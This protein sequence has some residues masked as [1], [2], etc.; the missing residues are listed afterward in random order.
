MRHCS[1][2][3]NSEDGHGA[4]MVIVLSRRCRNPITA[5]LSQLI[6]DIVVA[7]AERA[8]NSVRGGVVCLL[9]ARPI[10]SAT[11]FK[12]TLAA[13]V[14]SSDL[15]TSQVPLEHAHIA[16]AMSVKLAKHKNSPSYATYY[17]SLR[18][19]VRPAPSSLRSSPRVE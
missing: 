9:R 10:L 5:M 14:S 1:R 13:S 3:R 16:C 19:Y 18:P 11:V 2:A 7:L 12:L 6:R 17:I 15:L 4:R 8:S